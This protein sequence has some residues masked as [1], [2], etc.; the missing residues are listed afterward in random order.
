MTYTG[1]TEIMTSRSDNCSGSI[2]HRLT[3]RMQVENW[4]NEGWTQD[5]ENCC[6]EVIKNKA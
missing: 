3:N 5:I 4:Y 6:A 2:Q 1:F